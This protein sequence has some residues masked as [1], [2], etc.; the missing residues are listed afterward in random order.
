MKKPIH[1]VAALLVIGS[2]PLYS[3]EPQ[4]SPSPDSSPPPDKYVSREEY[5]KLKGEMEALKVQMAE[6]IK[7]QEATA[8]AEG[9]APNKE[10][11]DGKQVVSTTTSQNEIDELRDQ[12]AKVKETAESSRPGTTHFLLTGYGFAGFED[13]HGEKS[14]FSAGL[15]PI[16]LW[17]LSDRLFFESE[18]ELELNDNET[19]LNLEYAQLVYFLN[20]YITIGA[21]KFLSPSN[22]FGE[23]FH[24]AWINKLPDQPLAVGEEDGLLPFSEVGAEVR[25]GIPIGPVTL[26][27]AA[28]VSNGPRLNTGAD[29]A[30]SL[31]FENFTDTNDNKAVGGRVGVRILP[32]LE[33][34]YGIQYARVDASGTS[35]HDA[36]V[37]LQ[38][39]DLSYTR[40]IDWLKGGINVLG[41]WA[42][43]QVSRLTYDPDGSM[44]FGPVTFSNHRNGGYVQLAY[45]P[46]KLKVPVIDKLEL[47]GRYDRLDSPS[48]APGA[49]D[50]RRWTL[51]LNYWLGG[52]TVI[53]AAYEWGDRKPTGSDWEDANA[54]LLQAAMGF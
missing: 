25:G 54:F 16:F 33:A 45:R 51:G 37:L 30:G 27:Y 20:D 26:L 44:G 12:L 21:G 19:E 31:N 36:S 50:E 4:S 32:E 5:D 22:I 11:S 2:A 7:K 15:S 39:V 3:Q 48:N 13:R 17:Q 6:L 43:S 8:P 10:P 29:D 40:D 47:V 23:R 42:W 14:T 52:S 1:L 24:A 53:K 9:P 18:L 41:E 28:Y 34:G 35:S 49:F 38:A 46:S